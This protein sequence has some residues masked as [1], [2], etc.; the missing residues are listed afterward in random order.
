M[1]EVV[2]EAIEKRSAKDK[3]VFTKGRQET[4]LDPLN[5]SIFID[6]LLIKLFPYTRNYKL[7]YWSLRFPFFIFLLFWICNIFFF[8]FYNNILIVLRHSLP[9]WWPQSFIIIFLF[10]QIVWFIW[11]WLSHNK[12]Y[13]QLLLSHFGSPLQS[14]RDLL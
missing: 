9:S 11:Y 12:N 4:W 10:L 6:G 13:V 3:T 7:Y 8:V 5:W 1:E 2:D 14:H